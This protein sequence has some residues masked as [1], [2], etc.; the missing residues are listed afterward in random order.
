[1]ISLVENLYA[2]WR[3][4]FNSKVPESPSKSLK[5]SETKVDLPFLD[6]LEKILKFLSSRDLAMLSLTSKPLN[7]VVR[8]YVSHQCD[9]LN[10]KH[11]VEEFFQENKASL[12]PKEFALKERLKIN[13]RPLL[14]LHSTGQ[15]YLGNNFVFLYR[16]LLRCNESKSQ[17]SIH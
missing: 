3:F 9:R 5:V 1:M 13:S 16:I 11:Q 4:D 12:L 14:L 8:T 15:H 7:F 17:Q 2:R 6:I 10:L